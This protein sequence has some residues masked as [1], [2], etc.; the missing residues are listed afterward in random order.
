MSVC[1]KLL[2]IEQVM[3]HLDARHVPRVIFG[4]CEFAIIHGDVYFTRFR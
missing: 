4:R 3:K 1:Q 2:K